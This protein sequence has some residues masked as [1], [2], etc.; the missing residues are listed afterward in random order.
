MNLF[1]I[2]IPQSLNSQSLNLARYSH[3]DEN[4]VQKS[5]LVLRS[6]NEVC[7]KDY[8]QGIDEI[9]ILPKLW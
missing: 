7:M 1:L 6:N 2:L 5:D 4:G 8:I 3:Y 9:Q